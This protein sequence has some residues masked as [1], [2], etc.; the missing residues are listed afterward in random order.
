MYVC[1]P[2]TCL[3][4]TKARKGHQGPL[5]LVLEIVVSCLWVLRIEP[6]PLLSQW[7][8]SVACMKHFKR[9]FPCHDGDNIEIEQNLANSKCWVQVVVNFAWAVQRTERKER[10]T[11]Y[12]Q[13]YATDSFLGWLWLHVTYIVLGSSVYFSWLERCCQHCWIDKFPLHVLNQKFHLWQTY[14]CAWK[15]C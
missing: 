6:S 13:S 7:V 5:E 8:M 10:G 2:H 12:T 11:L 4:L 9:L 14:I 3:V 15:W 1:V